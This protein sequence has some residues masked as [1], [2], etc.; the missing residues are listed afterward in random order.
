MQEL[1]LIGN[2]TVAESVCRNPH[3]L[4]WIDYQRLNEARRALKVGADL[5]RIV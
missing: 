1:N 4:G 2:L 3:R 5:S